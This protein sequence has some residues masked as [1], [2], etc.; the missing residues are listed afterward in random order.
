MR[1]ALLSPVIS[2]IALAAI[3]GVVGATLGCSDA[4][5]PIGCGGDD[6]ACEAGFVCAFG[7]C[8][9]PNDQQLSTVDIE[10]NPAGDDLPVQSLF[11]VNLR[12]SPRV[13]VALAA[14][15]LV[16]GRVI[17]TDAPVDAVVVALPPSPCPAACSRPRRRPTRA[18]T[19]ASS[20][21]RGRRTT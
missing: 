8:I 15:V 14:G 19:T 5:A 1:R 3:V 2:H 16:S 17:D 6:R 12:E 11:G 20:R 21:S 13:D 10:V 18:A 9:D 4:Q 7:A